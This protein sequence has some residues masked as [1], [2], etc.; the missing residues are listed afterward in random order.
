MFYIMEQ[1]NII[2]MLFPDADEYNLILESIGNFV[3][4]LSIG[5]SKGD[6]KDIIRRIKGKKGFPSRHYIKMAGYRGS[7]DENQAYT[8]SYTWQ[9]MT[10]VTPTPPDCKSESI[11]LSPARVK[12]IRKK[13]IDVTVTVKYDCLVEATMVTTTVIVGKK[14]ISFSPQA[15]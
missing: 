8:L 6:A 11:G 3:E 9:P 10:A 4:R 15:N 14:R 5:I 12:L 7:Y 13:I 2:E 1:K